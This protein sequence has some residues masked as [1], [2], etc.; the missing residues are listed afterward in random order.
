MQHTVFAKAIAAVTAVALLFNGHA[1]AYATGNQQ[2]SSIEDIT[3]DASSP[4]DSSVN[5]DEILETKNKSS[6]AK[7]LKVSDSSAERE[8]WFDSQTGTTQTVLAI[9]AIM[10]VIGVLMGPL[11]MVLY[12]VLKI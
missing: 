4:F 2:Q 1:V 7:K 9:I 11:R 5:N 12:N 8:R 3:N 10:S 6:S